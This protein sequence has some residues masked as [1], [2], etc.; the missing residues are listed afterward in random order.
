MH[1]YVMLVSKVPAQEELTSM[2]KG[3][4][5]VNRKQTSV[6]SHV[7]ILGQPKR[8]FLVPFLGQSLQVGSRLK[9]PNVHV[10]RIFPSLGLAL[11]VKAFKA[12]VP[13]IKGT[14]GIHPGKVVLL[15]VAE[16]TNP[17][18]CVTVDPRLGQEFGRQN[19]GRIRL[20]VL[21]VQERKVSSNGHKNDQVEQTDQKRLERRPNIGRDLALGLAV[22]VVHEAA[23]ADTGVGRVFISGAGQDAGKAKGVSQEFKESRHILQGKGS[24]FVCGAVILSFGNAFSVVQVVSQHVELLGKNHLGTR[25]VQIPA[26]IVNVLTMKMSKDA[27]GHNKDRYNHGTRLAREYHKHGV[28]NDAGNELMNPLHSEGELQQKGAQK[29][30]KDVTHSSVWDLVHDHSQR[31]AEEETESVVQR[32]DVETNGIRELLHIVFDKARHCRKNETERE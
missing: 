2:P 8:G 5:G 1:T 15:S 30:R 17:H 19:D 13:D 3:T 29:K 31:I 24:T 6:C 26:Q 9:V 14:F 4:H 23:V 11:G 18:V 32:L 22:L 27:I 7:H 10:G 21:W 25:E 12:S 28:G 20:W 16:Q